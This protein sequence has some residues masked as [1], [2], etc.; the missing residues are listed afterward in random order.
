M[1]EVR[2]RLERGSRGLGDVWR[3]SGERFCRGRERNELVTREERGQLGR[4][5]EEEE[6]KKERKKE[7][8]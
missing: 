3:C 4:R 7:E 6:R 8:E 2:D 1:E 5:Q